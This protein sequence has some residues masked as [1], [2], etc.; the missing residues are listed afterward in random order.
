M[1]MKSMKHHGIK[2]GITVGLLAL[3]VMRST[4]AAAESPPPA[5][6]LSL[7]Y[8]QPAAD[9]K[10]MN[11]ALPIGN[12]TVRRAGLRLAPARAALL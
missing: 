10:P 9:A 11:E 1:E 7:W 2:G 6:P 5:Q 4:W 12:G 8:R 3:G